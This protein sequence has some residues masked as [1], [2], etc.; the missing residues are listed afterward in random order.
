MLSTTGTTQARAASSSSSSPWCGSRRKGPSSC[1]SELFPRAL[2]CCCYQGNTICRRSHSM[3]GHPPA[4]LQLV[5]APPPHWCSLLDL[6]GR[7]TRCPKSI[8]PRRRA[9]GEGGGPSPRRAGRLSSG[10]P[11]T[12]PRLCCVDWKQRK[13]GEQGR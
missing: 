3:Q 12:T 9:T 2:S 10:A 11:G 8:G 4:P 5:D 13:A 6:V 1:A 7:A